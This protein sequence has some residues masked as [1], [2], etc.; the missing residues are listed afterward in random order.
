MAATNPIVTENQ[1]PGNDGW[2]RIYPLGD[3]ATGQIRGYASAT[4]VLQ[5]QTITFYVTVNPVQTY[6]IDFYRIGWYQGVGGRLMPG[7]VG[8]L[9]G[10]QQ[11]PCVPDPTTGLIACN[12]TPSY[13]LTVPSGWTSGIYLGVLTN[14]QGYRFAVQFAVRDGRPAPFLYKQPVNTYQAY[15]NYPNDGRTGKSLYAFNS[16]GP[17]T[18]GGDARAVKV[19]FDRPYAGDGTAQFL[20][21]ELEFVRWLER[22][23]YDVTYTTDVDVHANGAE[24]RNHRAFLSVG[25]DEYWSK[26]MRDAVEGARDAGVNLAFFGADDALW[27]VRMESSATG[28]AN[29]VMVCYRDTS[30]DP[31]QGPTATVYWRNPPVNRPEQTMMGEQF[32]SAVAYSGA[33]VPYVVTNSSHWIYAGTGLKDGDG[34]PGIVGY[35]MDRYF[36]EFPAPTSTNQTLL[37]RSPFVIGGTTTPDYANSSIYQAPSGAWVFDAGTM[38]WSW[39]LDNIFGTNVEDARIKQTTANLLSAF[40]T[41]A[42]TAQ[43]LQLTAPASATAGLAFATTVAA[44]NAQGNPATAYT[45]TVHFSSTDPSALLPADYTFT[46]A[47]SGTH[48][49]QM[50]LK[51]AGSQTVT[52]TD[53]K[54]ASLTTRQ[55]VT[56][57]PAAAAN[58]T[59]T[60]LTAA[61]SG[62]A[63]TASVAATDA[64]G[65][66]ATGYSATVTFTSSDSQASLPANYTFVPAD[67]GVHSFAGGVTLRTAGT[68]SVTAQDTATPSLTSTQSVS[69]TAAVVPARLAVSGLTN[70]TAG[71]AQSVTVTAADAT[72]TVVTGYNGTIAFTSS[73]GQATLPARYTFVPADNG[74]HTFLAGVTLRTAGPQ[75]VTATDIASAGITG[76]QTVTIGPATLDHLALSPS[77]SSIAAGGSQSYT[78]TGFDQYGNNMADVTAGTA[79]TIAPDGSCTGASCTATVAGAHTVTGNNGGKTGL[80]SLTVTP[81]PLNQLAISPSSATITAGGSQSYTATG[82]DLYGNSLGDLTASTTFTIAPNGSCTGATCTATVAG[83]HSVTGSNSA[84]TASASLNVIAAAASQLSLAAPSSARMNQPFNV[85]VTLRDQYGNVATGYTG[86]VRLTSSDPLASLNLL[87]NVPANYTFTSTDAGTHTFSVTLMTMGNQTIT[88]T[89]TANGSLS[90]TR[91]VSVSLL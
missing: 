36:A 40:L 78:A 29:R 56:V 81:G 14:S 28:V 72:G 77:S 83:G 62:T 30:I 80:A 90:D 8:P 31:V 52:V 16:Y 71:T 42:P 91:T 67:R 58:L 5:G 48:Q 88:A 38:S 85:T 13:T 23:G 59:L 87:G 35:E 82:S 86:T 37:S 27:Q 26:E 39:A 34:V 55:T 64:Y 68:Q 76:S 61:T 70:A 20:N 84:R 4:S 33:N 7:S 51:T 74:V 44:A 24:V 2:R 32:T 17:N 11:A 41:G 9:S 79:F 46:Y 21:W 60:G 63:Q 89:D 3:D 66:A 53:T 18:V 19:S 65:N 12:W 75:M 43:T 15:N 69:I 22:S 57:G 47:D 73:D 10:M 6:T 54:T 1:Q 49:F 50:T 45:G 25:H